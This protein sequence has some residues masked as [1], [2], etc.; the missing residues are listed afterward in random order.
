MSRDAN[1]ALVFEGGR[2]K[3]RNGA[4][5][6]APR[7]YAKFPLFQTGSETGRRAMGR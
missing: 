5:P 6:L 1:G 7:D 3:S 2:V 4:P